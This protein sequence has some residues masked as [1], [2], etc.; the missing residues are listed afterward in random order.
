MPK[1]YYDIIPPPKKGVR[2]AK[3]IQAFCLAIILSVI[4]QFVIHHYLVFPFTLSNQEMEPSLKKGKRVYVWRWFESQ[5]I[6]RGQLVF[7]SHPE[8]PDYVS[9]RRVI[10]LP[11]EVVSIVKQHIYINGKLLTTNWEKARFKGRKPKANMVVEPSHRDFF[12]PVR[13]KEGEVFV[14]ADNHDLA[15]DSRL[16]GPLPLKYV[17]GLIKSL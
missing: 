10:A 13:I 6:K 17:Q 15:I 3:I 16:I 2:K 4:V 9:I 11:N 12:G 14:L 5:D 7:V 1:K 8:V